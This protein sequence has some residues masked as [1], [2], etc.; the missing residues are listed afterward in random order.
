MD[1][2]PLV[3]SLERRAD[4]QPYVELSQTLKGNQR[5]EVFYEATRFVS[6]LVACASRD[7]RSNDHNL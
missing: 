3:S 7:M 2:E 1:L 6:R 4:A 5:I